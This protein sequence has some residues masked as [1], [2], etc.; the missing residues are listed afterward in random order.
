MVTR[1]LVPPMIQEAFR[2]W[3][4]IGIAASVLG[5]LFLFIKRPRLKL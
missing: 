4:D 3:F 5:I 1:I 2:I